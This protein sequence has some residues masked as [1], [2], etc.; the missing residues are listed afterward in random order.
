MQ[1]IAERT[2]AN[3]MNPDLQL[4]HSALLWRGS[5]KYI[6]FISGLSRVVRETKTGKVVPVKDIVAILLKQI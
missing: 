4:C 2:K 1:E 6:I 3:H 5:E